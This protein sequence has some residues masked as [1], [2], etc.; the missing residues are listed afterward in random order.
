M[1]T[2]TNK[3]TKTKSKKISVSCSISPD[4]HKIIL[5]AAK[6]NKRTI[7]GEL[8]ARIIWS[9]LHDAKK[10]PGGYTPETLGIYCLK[11]KGDVPE[12]RFIDAVWHFFRSG[13][14]NWKN[15]K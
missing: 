4:M 12:Q 2:N 9:G 15:K 6:K 1:N 8:E 14:W 11:C 10:L 5:N 7:S 13:T 3:K